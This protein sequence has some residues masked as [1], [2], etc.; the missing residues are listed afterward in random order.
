MVDWLTQYLVSHGF[1]RGQ[2][3]QALFIKRED[4]E[5]I[6]AEVYVDDIIFGSTKHE[7][8]H[9]F[10]KLMQA[11]FEMS[12]IGE[13]NHFLGLQI[14]QQESGIFISQSKY[15]KNL[16]KKF[17]LESVSSVRTPIS[18]NVKL[19]VDLLGKGFDS[20]LYR[21]MIGSLVYLTASRPNISYSVGVCARYQANP[22][23]SHM[24]TLKRIIKYVKS[25]SDFG[26]WYSEDTNDVLP[27]YFDVD[28][29]GNADDRKSTSGG[30]FYVSNSISLSTAE[31][32]YIAT[33]NCCSQLLWMQN[34]LLDYGIRQEHLTIYCENT[35]AI[36]ISKNPIQHSQTK[37]I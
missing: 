32:K 1:T 10:S 4:G 29:V 14:R 17:G 5:L 35:S 18:P 27:R 26:V 2:V 37:H 24:I 30:C 23:K 36:N 11:E 34:L 28:W 25:T 7:L 33:G 8:A 20:S 19:T 6:V 15:A 12:M 21:S 31:A 3:D 22:K 13:L 16:V 9:N